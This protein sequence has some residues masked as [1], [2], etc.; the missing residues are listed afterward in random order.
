MANILFI[1]VNDINAAG[2]RS[3]SAYLTEK[4][5]ETSIIFLKLPGY[6]Y[7]AIISDT[8][9]NKKYL[10]EAKKIKSY[11]WVAVEKN[12]DNVRHVRGPKVT[13]SEKEI[14]ISQIKKISPDLIGFSITAPL[15]RRISKISKYIKTKL[16]IPIIWG[17]AGATIDPDEC[18][19]HCDFVCV[20]EG[21]KTLE[22][23]GRKIDQNKPIHD[24]NNLCYKRDGHVIKNPLNLLIKDLDNLPFIDINP[25]DKY[26]IENDSLVERFSKISYS[27]RYHMIGSRG[28]PYNCSYCTESYYKKLYAPA[29]FIRRR[30]PQNV[31]DEIK[32]A[33]KIVK[34]NFVQFEDEI[35]SLDYEWLKE[36][37]DI[38]KKEI[39]LPFFSYIYPKGNLDNQ[40]DLLKQTGL[41]YTCLA[42]QSGS[43]FINRD[44]FR[45]YFK[46]N[47]F[48][49]MAHKLESRGIPYYT[50]VIVHNFFENED[51]LKDTLDILL[52]INP[53]TIFMN[54][55]YVLKN[56]TLSR[57]V[58][59]GHDYRKM[60]Q[61][62]SRLNKYYINL[63]WLTQNNK[64]F[65]NLC[66]KTRMFRLFPSLLNSDL[67]ITK[68]K[69]LLRLEPLTIDQLEKW[70]RILENKQK[71][72]DKRGIKYLLAVTP[73][74]HT[75]YPE[76][77]FEYIHKI[78][79]KSSFKRRLYGNTN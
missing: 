79:R 74:K 51:D 23:I 77:L 65:V 3:L 45:R 41:A 71:W 44:I 48:I 28:C 53:F 31:I 61:I 50:D 67:L 66:Q 37:S 16:S 60:N 35:F 63:F 19:E 17:G 4:G 26:L 72:F 54:K 25:E 1:S 30:S 62:S 29:R 73:N 40:L 76:N 18:A 75:Y 43:E 64:E 47:H 33:Q 7:S 21:E 20:G 55:L 36:F 5:H 39:D 68:I 32:E 22:E 34:I 14:L 49:E 9:D 10:R 15:T 38:Y 27:G 24:V 42:L 69:Y 56:T 2:I 70:K 57:I 59:N 6:P 46:R 11:D 52:Q 58:E 78:S 13:D 8:S 12:G